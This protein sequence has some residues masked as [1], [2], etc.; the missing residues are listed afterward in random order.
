MHTHMM[1]PFPGFSVYRND[2][3]QTNVQILTNVTVNQIVNVL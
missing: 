2:T 1:R 3:I